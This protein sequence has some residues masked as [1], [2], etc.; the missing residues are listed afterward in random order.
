MWAET[1]GPFK[2][3]G[4]IHFYDFRILYHCLQWN[5]LVL[6]NNNQPTFYRGNSLNKQHFSAVEIM[7]KSIYIR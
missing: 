4:P 3:S 1:F 7:A 6:V 2:K 5:L